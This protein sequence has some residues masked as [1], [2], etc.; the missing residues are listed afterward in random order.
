MTADIVNLRQVRKRKARL[1][2]EKAAE[3]NRCLFGRSRAERQRREATKEL[4]SRKLDGN[5][6]PAAGRSCPP[7]DVD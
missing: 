2:R 4:E 7:N 3:T 1:E 5:R 6:L